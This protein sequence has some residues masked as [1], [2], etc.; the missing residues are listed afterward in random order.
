MGVRV[1]RLGV[2][3]KSAKETTGS[4]GVEVRLKKP[5]VG[6]SPRNLQG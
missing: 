6:E 5:S 2:S 3:E 1:I 4:G